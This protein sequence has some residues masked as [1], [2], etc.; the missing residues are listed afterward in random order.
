MRLLAS[1]GYRRYRQLA[2]RLRRRGVPELHYFH[3]VDDPY[4]HLA[5]QKLDALRDRYAVTLVPHLVVAEA[6]AFRGDPARYPGWAIAD[7]TAIAAG[8][9]LTFPAGAAPRDRAAVDQACNALVSLLGDREFAAAA[10]D[11]GARFWRGELAGEA[12]SVRAA[13]AVAAGNDLRR[14]LGHYAGGMF[15]FEGEWYWGVDRLC[16]LEARLLREGL[17]EGP[18]L[19]PRPVPPDT[20]GLGASGVTLEY[21][22]SLRSPY[23]AISFDRTM[24]L[25]ERSGVTLHLRPVMP[26]MMRGVPAPRSKQVYIMLDAAREAAAAG[27]PFGRIVDPFGEPVTRAFAL[28]PWLVES[29]KLGEFIGS[30]LRSAWARG[31]DITGDRG[32]RQVVEESGLSWAEAQRHRDLVS[33]RPMLDANLVA[34]LEAGLWGVPSYRV[35]GGD[36]PGTYACWGQDRLWRVEAEIAARAG[37][38]NA[39]AVP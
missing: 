7:A 18:P 39:T 12:S 8:Y 21:F 38:P 37:R 35:S 27:V 14:R 19:V 23:T 9:G 24:A 28:L 29:D 36:R 11:V 4:S 30:Y 15:W 13:E 20:T 3:Q 26:M 34:M 33:A 5:V 22:P 1:P 2:A 32:L 25:A 17:G 16:H 10:V 6:D 31:I